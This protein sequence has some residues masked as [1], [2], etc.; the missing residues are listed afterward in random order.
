MIEKR[1]QRLPHSWWRGKVGLGLRSSRG[2][3]MTGRGGTE[4][5]F[6]GEEWINANSYW[7]WAEGVRMGQ[8]VVATF[9][10]V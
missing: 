6:L 2:M 10:R 5:R 1:R 8:R 3:G 7:G 4:R 9:F